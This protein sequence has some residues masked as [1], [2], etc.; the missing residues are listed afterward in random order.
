MNGSPEASNAE[1][2][3]LEAAR[4][5]GWQLGEAD[6]ALKSARRWSLFDLLGGGFFATR[7]KH[8]RMDRVRSHLRRVHRALEKVNAAC[9]AL[10]ME[11]ASTEGLDVSGDW[12]LRSWD[13]W[14]D[15]PLTDWRFHSRS[16]EMRRTIERVRAQ[17]ERLEERL[18]SR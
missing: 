13:A 8:A 14:V 7:G 16:R 11:P 15:D 5:A 9:E 6:Q 4:E 17:L 3:L 10:A 2:L 1:A 12:N 18:A